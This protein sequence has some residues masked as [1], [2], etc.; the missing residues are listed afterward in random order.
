VEGDVVILEA[1]DAV[2]ADWPCPGKPSMKVE[3]ALSG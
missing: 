1:G 3:E 2:P